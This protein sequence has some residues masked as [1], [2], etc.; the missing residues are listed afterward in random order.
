[1]DLDKKPDLTAADTENTE[2]A[3]SF[4]L[5][6]CQ[7]CVLCVCGGEIILALPSHLFVDY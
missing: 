6:L 7:L 1:M 3:Q 4:I 5:S 2:G